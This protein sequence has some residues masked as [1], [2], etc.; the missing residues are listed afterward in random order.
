MAVATLFTACEKYNDQFEGME[1]NIHAPYIDV[2]SVTLA[3]ADYGTITSL[4][5]KDAV[6]HEDSVIVNSVGS[7]KYFSETA[8]SSVFIPYF[9]MKEYNSFDNGAACIVTFNYA[10]NPDYLPSTNLTLYSLATADYDDMGT[11][12]LEPGEYNNFSADVIS[13]EWLPDWLLT[14]YPAAVEGEEYVIVYK[15]YGG[16]SPEYADNYTFNGTT[17]DYGTTGLYLQ[18]G[19]YDD[20]GE[21]TNKPG[22]YNNFSSSIDPDYYLPLWLLT[23]YPSAKT[24]DIQ[25]VAYK[26]YSGSTLANIQEYYFNGSSWSSTTE[27]IEKTEQYLFLDSEWKFDPSVEFT[28]QKSDYAIIVSYVAANI[29]AEYLDGYGT[30][31]FYYGAS[32]YYG[33]FDFQLY[34]RQNY[35]P[36]NFPADMTEEDGL[37][38]M[39]ERVVEGINFLLQA[40]YPDAVPSV[41]GAD[42]YYT[43][44]YTTY[45]GSGKY[46]YYTVKY[47]CTANGVFTLVEGPTEN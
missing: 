10:I 14:K 27:K 25:S 31:E 47:Q 17:W 40:K 9:L 5:I 11:G 39:D 4:A 22:Q 23:K 41:N 1:D 15:Y 7:N 16:A 37:A 13:Y 2:T 36:T 12:T 3:D 21:G 18:T 30:A 38:L 24:G 33:N 26:Y 44:N 6:S 45:H 46:I 43:V 19:D 8:P 29:G 34:N 35:D 42:V 32:G 20:M 28:M